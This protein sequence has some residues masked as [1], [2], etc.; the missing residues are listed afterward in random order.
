MPAGIEMAILHPS[1]PPNITQLTR[2]T[3]WAW[4]RKGANFEKHQALG[5]ARGRGLFCANTESLCLGP[6][7]ATGASPQPCALPIPSELPSKVV[8]SRFPLLSGYAPSSTFT[9]SPVHFSA[10]LAHLPQDIPLCLGS[11]A[12]GFCDVLDQLSL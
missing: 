8:A 9:P 12:P 3:K 7:D 6:V 11:H 5:T 2:C 4:G 1:L 10:S